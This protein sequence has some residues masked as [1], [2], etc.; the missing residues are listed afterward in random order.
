MNNKILRITTSVIF[1]LIFVIFYKSLQETNIYTPPKKI[2]NEIP[3]FSAKL[4]GSNK[5]INSTELFKLNKSYLLNIWSSWCVPCRNEHSLLMELTK[6][7]NV[8]IIGLNYKD[9]R[10]NAENFLN[11]LGNPY[12]QIIFDNEGIHAI[13]WGAFGV[14]ESFLINDG[15]VIKKYIGPLNKDSIEEIKLLIK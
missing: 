7:N 4:F 12:Q 3:Y 10:K 9:K 6:N 2:N 15:I 14:P 1:I 5:Q 13:E 8:E 11:E